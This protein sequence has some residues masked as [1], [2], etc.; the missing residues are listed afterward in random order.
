LTEGVFPAIIQPANGCGGRDWFM[1]AP[2]VH[3]PENSQAKG[4]SQRTH[5]GEK[6]HSTRFAEGRNVSGTKDRGGSHSTYG[7]LMNP[8]DL[9]YTASHEWLRDNGDGTAT[10]GITHHAQ[11]ALGDLVYVELPAIGR[12][13]GA[14]EAC[15]VVESTKAA[16]DVYSPLAGQVLAVNDALTD[17]PQAINESPFAD[18]WIFKIKVDQA[19]DIAGLLSAAQY[20]L[21][22]V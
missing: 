8:L 13:L 14:G 20:N 22:T 3:R 16:S 2:K 1:P 4:L 10:I 7:A 18:G 5:S 21:K 15:V 11:D 19:A 6:P 17:S 9:K 12:V